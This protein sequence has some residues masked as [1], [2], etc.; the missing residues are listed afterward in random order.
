MPRKAQ[1]RPAIP[2]AVKDGLLWLALEAELED[3]ERLGCNFTLGG[4]PYGAGHL[5]EMVDANRPRP[6]FAEVR[7]ALALMREG[8]AR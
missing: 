8:G 4:Q 3:L 1:P 7:A 5:L 6:T 2:Q